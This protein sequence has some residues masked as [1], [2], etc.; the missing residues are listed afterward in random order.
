MAHSKTFWPVVR[1]V[2]ALRRTS[3]AQL[4]AAAGV[5]NAYFS[6]CAS[7]NVAPAD[8]RV[9]RIAETLQVSVDVLMSPETM[10]H[11]EDALAGRAVLRARAMAHA[12]E[13]VRLRAAVEACDRFF[14]ETMPQMNVVASVLDANA[15]AAW[16]AA[17]VAAARVIGP[18]PAGTG[19]RE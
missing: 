9:A 3:M 19:A 10:Q 1:L 4:A 11:I 18:R 13:N 15:I 5:S 16:N 7:G 8:D 14:R 6:A 17:E 2:V 12:D